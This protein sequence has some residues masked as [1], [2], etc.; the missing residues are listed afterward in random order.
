[1]PPIHLVND[2]MYRGKYFDCTHVFPQV[3][4]LEPL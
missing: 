1:V 2:F 4:I 3:L